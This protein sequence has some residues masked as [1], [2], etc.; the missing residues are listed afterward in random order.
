[1]HYEL[2]YYSH[3]FND[4]TPNI[5]GLELFEGRA[6]HSKEFRYEE[7]FDGLRVAILGCH[8]SGEDISMHVAKFAKKVMRTIYEDCSE[9][10]ETFTLIPLGKR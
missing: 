7:H 6:I 9:V 2:T 3:D 5:P 10:I 4:Y 1:M 8:Y